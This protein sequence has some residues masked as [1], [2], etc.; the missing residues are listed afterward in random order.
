MVSR[1]E[2]VALGARCYIWWR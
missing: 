1:T 2:S